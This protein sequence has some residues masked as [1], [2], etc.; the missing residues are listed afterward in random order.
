MSTE[1]VKAGTKDGPSDVE[2]R[3]AGVMLGVT[4]GVVLFAGAK[5]GAAELSV[6]TGTTETPALVETVFVL[7][8][9]LGPVDGPVL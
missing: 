7:E 2:L 5:A 4:A 9:T 6:D 1:D 3:I 8:V